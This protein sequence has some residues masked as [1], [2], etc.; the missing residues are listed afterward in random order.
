MPR[1]DSLNMLSNS[2]DMSFS[3]ISSIILLVFIQCTALINPLQ[4]QTEEQTTLYMFNPLLF[5]PAYAGSR[6][7]VSIHALARFQWVGIDGAPSSQ[8]LSVHS[9]LVNQNLG[10]GL[11]LSNDKIGARRRTSSFVDFAYHLR[12][13]KRNHRLSFGISGGIDWHVFDFSRLNTLDQADPGYNTFTSKIQPNFGLGLYYYGDRHYI[14]FSVPRILKNRLTPDGLFGETLQRRHYY[15]TG[16]YVFRLSSVVDFKP[17]VLLKVTENAPV[18]FDVNLNFLFMNRLWIG[19]YYRFNESVGLNM[20]VI[21]KDMLTIGYSFDYPYNGLNA[22]R[23]GHFGTH[24]AVLVVDIKN[25]KKILYSPRY[26]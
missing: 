3:K 21:V 17:S 23:T 19:P 13:N 6:G 4:A 11:H 1:N 7:A 8:F 15:F 16:G 5:N 14:G 26:F 22:M 20:A 2:Y 9:P 24:E 25:K 18:T 12:L 10:I